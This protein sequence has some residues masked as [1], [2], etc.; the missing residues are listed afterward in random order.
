MKKPRGPIQQKPARKKLVLF[1]VFLLIATLSPVAAETTLHYDYL[2]LNTTIESTSNF[3]INGADANN[4]VALTLGSPSP[5]ISYTFTYTGTNAVFIK[6]SS[7]NA[8]GTQMRLKHL[9]A[10]AFIPYEMRFDYDGQGLQTPQTVVSGVERELVK[11]NNTYEN[12]QGAIQFITPS[13]EIYLA[14][15]YKDTITFSFTGI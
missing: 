1:L 7:A 14:G 10:D 2:Y 8:L 5:P 11:Y 9:D 13:D 6:I 15:D 3:I 12:L 4:N